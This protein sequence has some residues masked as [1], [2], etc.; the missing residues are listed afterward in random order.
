[1]N[2]RIWTKIYAI[3]LVALLMA[4]LCCV[5][6]LA[7]N[8]GLNEGI[9][10]LAA[11]VLSLLFAPALHEMGHVALAAS[12]GMRLEYVKI[13]CFQL[14]RKKGKLRFSLCSPFAPDQTQVCPKSG[15]DMKK[16]AK[17]YTLG[18][19]IFEGAFT[20]IIAFVATLLACFGI[21]SFALWGL[22]PYCAYL[23]FL[24][25]VPLEYPSGKT[26]ALVYIGL[27][28]GAPAEENMLTAMEIQGRLYAGESYAEI[29]ET[30]YFSAPQLCEDEPLFS[31]MRYLQYRYFLEKDDKEKA[32]DSLNRLALAQEYLSDTERERI[33][34]ELVYFHSLN[35]DLERAQACSKVCEAFLRA[36]EALSK[37]ALAAYCKAFGKDEAVAQ[38]IAQAE[39]LLETERN[40]GEAKA[41]RIL[42]SR[43]A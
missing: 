10:A 29:E 42:L 43:L 27:K 6:L 25:A 5:A 31:I 24:N 33:A 21:N 4:G 1:M 11:I 9:F 23:F 16:R 26:D 40:K 19:L 12:A 8:N 30:V 17:L 3:L 32:A 36:D 18:G 35:G 13:F 2:R 41:E 34:A 7:W 28:T 37:R 20:L 38:L 39:S 14:Q 15:G 22:L